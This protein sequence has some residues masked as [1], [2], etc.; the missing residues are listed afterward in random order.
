[1]TAIFS[2]SVR[3]TKLKF[4]EDRKKHHTFAIKKTASEN[5]VPVLRN[6]LFSKIIIFKYSKI[7]I[8]PIFKNDVSFLNRKFNGGMKTPIDSDNCMSFASPIDI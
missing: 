5:F 4:S 3:G 1:M 2:K 7:I 6:R 8:F